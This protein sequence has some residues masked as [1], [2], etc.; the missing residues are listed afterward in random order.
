MGRGL[1]GICLQLGTVEASWVWTLL[2][3]DERFFFGCWVFHSRFCFLTFAWCSLYC[4]FS[5]NI[6]C[7]RFWFFINTPKAFLGTN[8]FIEDWR[9][10]CGGGGGGGMLRGNDG[11][12]CCPSS[13]LSTTMMALEVVGLLAFIDISCGWMPYL[14]PQRLTCRR[15]CS[16]DCFCP[17]WL[18]IGHRH[19]GCSMLCETEV[20]T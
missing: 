20:G 11:A 9:S 2:F 18:H 7:W 4:W 3:Q 1:V 14:F 6:W 12:L 8:W 17:S 19:C 15:R 13:S 5:L 10:C 16:V